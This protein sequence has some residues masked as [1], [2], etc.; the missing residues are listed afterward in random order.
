MFV[1]DV[2]R[3]LQLYSFTKILNC[4]LWLKLHTEDKYVHATKLEPEYPNYEPIIQ[5][6]SAISG[7]KVYYD[8]ICDRHL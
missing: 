5:F 7:T 1:I 8:E 6:L 2:L 3:G 4:D